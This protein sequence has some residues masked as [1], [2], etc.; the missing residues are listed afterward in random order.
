MAGNLNF[1]FIFRSAFA[2]LYSNQFVHNRAMFMQP[3]YHN[4]NQWNAGPLNQQNYTNS[5]QY[6]YGVYPNQM[7]SNNYI[8]KRDL[9]GIS[10]RKEKRQYK[11]RKNKTQREKIGEH[12]LKSQNKTN[13][14]NLKIPVHRMDTI[15]SDEEETSN[16]PAFDGEDEGNFSFKR[17][18]NC[19]YFKVSAIFRDNRVTRSFFRKFFSSFS[20]C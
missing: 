2:P 18:K 13:L 5:S 15:S 8:S 17:L 12:S 3:S 7:Q 16:V 1:T 20:D 11:K 10:N 6:H 14:M 9:D 19:N 4:Q